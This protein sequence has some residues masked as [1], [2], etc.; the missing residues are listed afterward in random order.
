MIIKEI[1]LE[2]LRSHRESKIDFAEGINVIT[3]NTGSGKS[4]ILMAIEYALFGKIGEGREEGRLLLRRGAQNGSIDLNTEEKGMEYRIVRGLKKVKD[5]VRNDDSRNRVERDGQVLDLQNRAGDLNTFI[6]RLLKIESP[7][8]I[9]TFEAI[10][11]IKQDELKEL[12]FETGKIKQEYID[13]LLQLNKYA[14]VYDGMKEIIAKLGEDIELD[15]KEASMT[16]DEAEIIRIETKI[17]GLAAVAKELEKRLESVKNEIGNTE[18]EKKQADSETEFFRKSKSEYDSVNTEIGARNTQKRRLETQ[19]EELNRKLEKLAGENAAYD[20]EE[21]ERLKNE[22]TD[23]DRLLAEKNKILKEKY[24]KKVS[25]ESVYNGAM[26]DAK[27]TEGE[28]SRLRGELE[29]RTAV[30]HTIRKKLD[31]A[32][33]LMTRDEIRGV[34]G[35]LRQTIERLKKDKDESIRKGTCALCGNKIT[36]LKHAE[37]EYASRISDCEKQMDEIKKANVTETGESKDELQ[38]DLDANDLIS[39]Q[40]SERLKETESKLNARDANKL[41]LELDSASDEYD[42]NEREV[43]ALSKEIAA[44][45]LSINKLDGVKKGLDEYRRYSAQTQTLNAN[46]GTIDEELEPLNRKLTE[47]K[48]DPKNLK[49]SEERQASLTEALKNLGADKSR[50]ERE[51]ELRKSETEENKAKLEEMES[52][53]LKKK[54]LTAKIQRGERFLNLLLRLREDIRSIREYVRNRFINDFRSLFQSR[55]SELRTEND[56]AIDIDNNYNLLV[57]SNDEVLDAKTLSGGEKTSVALA[58][59]LAL[60]SVASLLGGVGKNEMVIM[61][62]PT[63]G[64]DKEDIN[65]LTNAITKINDLR[66]IIIV[67]HEENMKNIA[68]NLITIRK[69]GGESLVLKGGG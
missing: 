2:N 13:Q 36:D 26:N 31:S 28:I 64:L 51:M 3:G 69:E 12:I 27:A 60:S 47:M 43:N 65:A 1:E 18:I 58:Y 38:R 54:D 61:D 14:D 55:F 52:K 10:T 50:L 6:N 68:D 45:D 46:A 22:R 40:L 35:Q 16:V 30:A 53:I 9:K 5:A 44:L 32:S 19:I 39:A 21:V 20:E 49:A 67:T 24:G 48:F 56:Y 34:T 66:Q 63:S 41:K 59:R 11:Y 62:E 57:V 4:S 17:D 29:K 8:P 23:K 33:K 25:A 37:T 7:D 15:K 42:A